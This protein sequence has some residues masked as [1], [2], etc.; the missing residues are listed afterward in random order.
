MQLIARIPFIGAARLLLGFLVLVIV[1]HLCVLLGWIPNSIVWG[2]RIQ[3]REE[4][5]ALESISLLVNV[6]LI[7][8]VAQKAG[9]AKP[10][11]S[12]KVLSISLWCLAG[13]FAFNTLGNLMSKSKFE[14]LVFTP[15]TF[16]SALL[17]LRLAIGNKQT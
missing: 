16:V 10:L 17:C 13:L 12:E 7:W 9:F 5:Y 15:L 6:L 4:F 2:G 8:I 11:L 1:F 3:T 14:M